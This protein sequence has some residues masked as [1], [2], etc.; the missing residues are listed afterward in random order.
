MMSIEKA[1]NSLINQQTRNKEYG[2]DFFF[3]Y[4]MKN[5]SMREI[6]LICY[7][8]KLKYGGKETQKS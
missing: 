1:L 5:E 7:K 8:K 6:V 3:S 4:N 2:E